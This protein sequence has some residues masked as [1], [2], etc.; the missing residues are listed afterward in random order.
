ME[1]SIDHLLLHPHWQEQSVKATSA[2]FDDHKVILCGMADLSQIIY[3][4]SSKGNSV[5]FCRG[6]RGIRVN[7]FNNTP[8]S[9]LKRRKI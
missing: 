4:G 3:M 2:T 9:C 6:L 1:E 7:A 5:K 8:C